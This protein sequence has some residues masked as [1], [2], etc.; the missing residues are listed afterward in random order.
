MQPANLVYQGSFRV[1]HEATGEPAVSFTYGGTAMAFNA[2]RGSLFLVGHDQA[3]LVAEISVPEI[4]T[5]ATA[6]LATATL[7]QPFADVTE[8]RK[9]TLY[10]GASN[11]KI[12]GLLPYGGA[13]YA[14][15]YGYYDGDGAQQLSHFVSG[16]D[17]SVTGDVQGPFKVGTVGAGV[18]AGYLGLVPK[19]WQAAVG[20]PVLTGQ[21]CISV[22][23][24]SS[25]GPAVFTVD[26]AQLGVTTPAPATPLVYY[27]QAHPIG[28]GLFTT[29]DVMGGVVFPEGTR[30]VLF[31]GR[32]GVG[33]YC[34]GEP[35]SDQTLAATKVPDE[36]DTVYCLDPT[37]G[38][39]GD[40][41][42]PYEY[43]VWAYD[44]ND[45]AAVRSGK[46]QPWDV[47][48]YATW[49]PDL[50]FSVPNA[51]IRGAA[52][53]PASGRIFLS[54]AWGDGSYPLIHV[55]SIQG[56]K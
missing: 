28:G 25:Y 17:L 26:P 48:P 54:Q 3:Q 47:K 20:G 1:P 23:S 53:D 9:A 46:V 41:A 37:G 31:F 6:G 33:P 39:K 56:A 45:L 12:G 5:G 13:L 49:K 50:P 2:A 14:T 42:Y 30:S 4:R 16:T 24:R 18:V 40:H 43:R 35:T 27:P 21:C 32:Q 52:Y 29:T 10:P 55:F 51:I 8:G 7:L 38:G 15:V 11:V 19:A 36:G 44:A 34:Y 22:I